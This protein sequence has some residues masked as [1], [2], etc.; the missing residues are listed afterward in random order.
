MANSLNFVAGEVILFS[1][2]EHDDYYIAR[3]GIVIQDFDA[4]ALL[5]VWAK[6]HGKPLSN[7]PSVKYP[8]GTYRRNPNEPEFY[9]WLIKNGYVALVKT[10]ELHVGVCDEVMLSTNNYVGSV[11]KQKGEPL[12]VD[13]SMFKSGR[14][15]WHGDS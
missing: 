1:R 9:D 2:E 8:A 12:D 4:D 15:L 14:A 11:N 3:S 10:R 6:E 13:N 7:T 5:P